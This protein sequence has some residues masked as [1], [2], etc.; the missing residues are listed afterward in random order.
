MRLDLAADQERR[1]PRREHLLAQQDKLQRLLERF[2]GDVLE[3]IGVG[4][5]LETAGQMMDVA[6]SCGQN[7]KL[8]VRV[9][10]PKR[11]K[12]LNIVVAGVELDQSHLGLNSRSQLIDTIL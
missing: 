10:F 6:R 12:L 1:K 9:F 4:S 3:Q 7:N 11:M 8:H 5:G 2:R